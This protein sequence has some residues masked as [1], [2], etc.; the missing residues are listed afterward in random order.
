MHAV[1]LRSSNAWLSDSEE[2][3]WQFSTSF[4]KF[5][6]VFFFVTAPLRVVG[7]TACPARVP[8]DPRRAG[9]G[10]RPTTTFIP[11]GGRRAMWHSLTVAAEYSA[12]VFPSR[13]G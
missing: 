4:Q 5:G 10:A 8:L 12:G 1:R 11:I 9:E 2:F 7:R 3:I 6:D 13:Y